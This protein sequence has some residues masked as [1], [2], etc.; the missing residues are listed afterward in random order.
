MMES[1]A[2]AGEEEEHVGERKKETTAILRLTV[3]LAGDVRWKISERGELFL[4]L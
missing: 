1:A 2:F 4:Q 3:V